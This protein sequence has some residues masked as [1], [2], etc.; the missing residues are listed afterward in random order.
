MVASNNVSPMALCP[1]ISTYGPV[2]V[3]THTRLSPIKPHVV[4]KFTVRFRV[5]LSNVY[6]CYHPFLLESYILASPAAPIRTAIAIPGKI[7]A[8][9]YEQESQPDN[10]HD[11][12]GQD[13]CHVI[14][15]FLL[16]ILFVINSL[17]PYLRI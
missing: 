2:T 7:Q 13:S 4:L 3:A 9:L 17:Y 11:C 1:I 14:A 8:I 6:M 15:P 16:S 12:I 10:R 5:L